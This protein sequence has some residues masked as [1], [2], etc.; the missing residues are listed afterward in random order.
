MAKKKVEVEVPAT[1]SKSKPKGR[2]V[3]PIR[4]DVSPSDYGR[5]LSCAEARGLTLASYAR[6]ALLDFLKRDEKESA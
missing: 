3:K 5:A 4:L 1:V 2:N 6:M